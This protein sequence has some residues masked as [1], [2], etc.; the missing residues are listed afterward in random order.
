MS[1]FGRTEYMLTAEERIAALMSWAE[2]SYL[3]APS[4]QTGDIDGMRGLL[5]TK[6]IRKGGLLMSVPRAMAMAVH[7][8]DP[9]PFPMFMGDAEW[10]T[11]PE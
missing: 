10:N 8:G 11:F 1:L 6:H 7:E 2:N 3:Y 4:L 9:C 5:A